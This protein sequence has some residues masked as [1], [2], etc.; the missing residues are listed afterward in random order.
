MFDLDKWQEILATIK[1]NK[2]RT[3]LTGFSVAWGIFM[4]IILLGSGKGLENGFENQFRGA[5]KNSLWIWTG[6]TSIAHNGMN[7]GRLIRFTNNDY[8]NLKNNV[9]QTEYISGRFNIWWGNQVSYNNEVHSFGIRNVHP[10]YEY[11]EALKIKGGR[12]IN[13]ID[14]RERRKV[15]VISTLVRDVLFKEDAD[16]ALGKY[17]NVNGI[18]FKVVGFFEDDSQRESN[19]RLIY[20]PISTAQTVFSGGNRLHEIS[21]TIKANTMEEAQ[22]AEKDIRS[23]LAAVHNFDQDDRRAL[24]TWNSFENYMQMQSIFKGIRLFIW[25]IGIGTIIAG[26]VGVSN[27]MLIVVKERTREIGV[28]KA[29]GATPASVISLVLFESVLITTFAGYIGLVLGVGLLEMLSGI[30]APFFANPSADFGLAVSATLI[31]IIAGAFAGFVPARRAASIKPI[32]ALRD[33]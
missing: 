17:I 1:K 4:L 19:M 33:E 14:I 2:L 18:P 26:I 27:I 13:H 12:Y 3:F 30:D 8:D 7:P 31:L 25:I 16:N 28:R 21:M 22:Q 5:A 24:G 23:R 11:I 9:S 10:D 20:V 29:L 32:E 15:T 6:R